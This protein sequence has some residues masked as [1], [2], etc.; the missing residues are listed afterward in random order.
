MPLPHNYLF[1]LT[2]NIEEYIIYKEKIRTSLSRMQEITEMTL[3]SH[4]EFDND[5]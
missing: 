5:E 3:A 4:N 2:V 1:A